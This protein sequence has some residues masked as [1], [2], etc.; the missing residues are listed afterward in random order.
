MNL[1]TLNQIKQNPCARDQ[2][3]LYVLDTFKDAKL[4]I[5]EIGSLRDLKSRAGDGWSSVYWADYVDRNGGDFV[6]S[7]INSDD[8]N[9]CINLISELFPYNE[10]VY[11][12]GD[13]SKTIGDDFDLIYLDGGDDPKETLEQFKKCGAIP[14][15]IDDFHTK[16]RLINVQPNVLFEFDNG[17]QMA[18]F[19]WS[20]E[21]KVVEIKV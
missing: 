19:D 7:N 1:P 9:N 15:L 13:G 2:V 4:N 18:F 6:T 5:L 8:L 3:F 14:T 17:H 12:E 10:V 21:F 16:G 20:G 11:I